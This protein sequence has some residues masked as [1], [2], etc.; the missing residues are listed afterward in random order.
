MTTPGQELRQIRTTLGLT[1]TQ[2][3][4]ALGFIGGKGSIFDLESGRKNPSPRTLRDARR[5]LAEH[6]AQRAK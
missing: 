6:E 3:A 4:E 5:L 2:F 1:Q